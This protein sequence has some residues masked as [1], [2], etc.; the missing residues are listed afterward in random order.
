VTGSSVLDV[1]PLAALLLDLA[2]RK[3]SGRLAFGDRTLVLRSGDVADILPAPDDDSLE[4]FLVKSGRMSAATLAPYEQ[5][6]KGGA[7]ADVLVAQGAL[8]AGDLRQAR[9]ALLLDRLTRALRAAAERKGPLPSIAEMQVHAAAGA[10]VTLLPFLLDALA[11]Y[12]GSEDAA[13]VGAHLNHRIEWDDG[14]HAQTARAWADLGETPQRPAVSTVLAKRPA[15]APRIAALLRAGLIRLDAPGRA[16]QSS[17]P[18]AASLPPP[19]PRAVT[20]D[21]PAP[22]RDPLAAVKP[23]RLRLD[24][25]QVHVSAEPLASTVLPE[26]PPAGDTPSD[27]LVP[28]EQRIAEL[29]AQGAS[30]AERARAFCAIA[31]VWRDRF[32][33]LERACRAFREAATADPSLPGVLQ[34]AAIHCH[35]LG[36]HD[37]AL[38]YV[39]AAVSAAG[40]PVE[41]AGAQRLRARI[42][43]SAGDGDACI[44]ALC[45]AAAD[46]PTCPDSHEQVATLL[47]ERGQLEGANAHARLAATAIQEDAPDRALALLSFAWWLKPDDA[48]T[49]YEYASLLDAAGQR[50]VAVAVLAYTGNHVEQVDQGRKLRLAA[51]ERAEASGRADIAAELLVEAFDAE[52]HFDLLYGPLDED[53]AAIGLCEYRA[54]VLEDVATECPDE[55]RAYWLTRAAQVLL[56]AEGQH[57][58]AVWLLYEALLTEPRELDRLT[59]LRQHAASRR[60]LTLF[61]HGLRAAIAARLEHGRPAEDTA[62]AKRLL[63]E[64]AE[65]AQARLHNPHL[66]LA[67][68]QQRK[69]MGEQDQAAD[70]TIAS[71]GAAI[72]ARRVELDRAEQ[73][74]E[75]ASKAERA[76]ASLRVARL[77]PDI[78]EHWPRAIQLLTEGLSA[79]E[80]LEATR[81][82]LETLYGLSRDAIALATFLEEQAELCQDRVE[83]LRILGRLCAVHTVREDTFAVAAVCESLIGLDPSSRIAIARLERAARRLG[84]TRRLARALLLRGT[85][86][87][88]AR[89]RGRALVQLARTE[90]LA[91]LT[92]EAA[93]HAADALREDPNAA[94]AA[95]LLL[96]HIDRV[97]PE[98]AGFGLRVAAAV[99]GPSRALLSAQVHAA[100]ALADET[101]ERAALA[102][103]VALL[104]NDAAAHRACMRMRASARDA[105]GLLQAAEAA[106]YAI[107][108]AEMLEAAREAL[109]QLEQL[110]A[111][112]QAAELALR[113]AEEQGRPDPAL[114]ARALAAARAQPSH[115]LTAR[116]LEL[117][118]A[119]A[120]PGERA[121]WLFALADHH[122]DHGQ[123]AA[124]I[125]ALLRV[126]ELMPT[127]PAALQR[128]RELFVATGD[129]ARLLGVLHLSLDGERD[130]ARRRELRLQLCAIAA[131]PLQ[132]RE[133]AEFHVRALVAESF[134]QPDHVREALGV[135]VTLGGPSWAL[136]RCQVIAESCP[137]ELGSRIYQWCA[138]TA[139]Q[140]LHDPRL[141]FEVARRGALRWPAYAELLLMVERL[142]LSAD[143]THGAMEVYDAL[144]AAAIGP[145]GRRA[146]VYRAGRWLERAGLLE[147]ALARYVDAFGLAPSMGAAFKAV[148]RVARQTGQPERLVPCYEQLA[149]QSR[150]GRTRAAL[151]RTA[152]ELCVRELEDRPRGLSLLMQANAM[153][154]R[155][156][157]DDRLLEVARDLSLSDGSAGRVAMQQLAFE[158]RERVSQLWNAEDKL[159]CLLRLALVRSEGLGEHA[160]ALADLD[161]AQRVIEGEE[162]PPESPAAIEAARAVISARMTPSARPVPA[163]PA[164]GHPMRDSE[165]DRMSAVHVPAELLGNVLED[166]FPDEA[167]SAAASLPAPALPA[168]D[169]SSAKPAA[170]AETPGDARARLHR[171]LTAEPWRID[172]LRDLHALA[173][174]QDH[175]AERHVARQILSIFDRSV[176][177]ARDT[178]FHSGMWRGQAL[179]TSIGDDP[180]PELSGLLTMLWECARVIPRFRRPLASYG[181]NERDRI[182]RIT[183]GPVAEAYAQAARMLG[184]TDV[185]VYLLLSGRAPART[186]AT[187]PPAVLAS[188]G[189]AEEPAA[190]LYAM[191]HALWLAQPER[192]IGGVLP[193][194]EA[195]ELIDAARLA[196][197]PALARHANAGSKELAAALWQSVP[198]RDQRVMAD[199]LRRNDDALEYDALRA[200]ARSSAARAALLASGG[201]RFALTFLANTEPELEGVDLS[202]EPQ[203]ASACLGSPAL[204]ETIRCALSAPFMKALAQL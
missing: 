2:A 27:P 141:A 57:E 148:E 37:L 85:V 50:A 113:L 160:A 60:E 15:A 178:A 14:P 21:E 46:D 116:A 108:N 59:T 41:R 22:A 86:A 129:A 146:L 78:P 150:D 95:L 44:E 75:R 39:E 48:P 62:E 26:L 157:L 112:A 169:P 179:R 40:I 151:L 82:T 130:P 90:E 33:S 132:D 28:L 144:I 51:A 6:A 167:V 171:L 65:L 89:E 136:E 56:Q 133:R 92:T 99:C 191:A 76:R 204:A 163:E 94:D 88:S 162:L 147:P 63:H 166:V 188:R 122:R 34:Q 53:L 31:D 197:A 17:P 165:L 145:H 138:A 103:W 55:Q 115:R 153:S 164:A 83:R 156:E 16:V 155:Y 102:G 201:L 79:G 18:A 52:P 125:R 202:S 4:H 140:R 25:G 176:S 7:I 154:E 5:A 58:A 72:R 170:P 183:I 174:A 186:L 24:P 120:E 30:G 161:E 98:V 172:A 117:R 123:S 149:E 96:R 189:V 158:L 69:R 70:A 177:V 64:L 29:E 173:T 124:E 105:P 192:M 200:R 23:P 106:L 185:P 198:T 80:E 3:V 61:A 193:R 134:E 203:F 110:G 114:A 93:A 45:E 49:A 67:A 91:G 152:G 101:A 131:G 73:S 182:S 199:V 1:S 118:V 8:N 43:R 19:L 143:D 66:A 11:R 38:R 77:L 127:D 135:L 195:V 107:P 184:A 187:H 71:L 97:E 32:A 128:L 159:R 36:Q 81:E 196:F 87:Q 119:I 126:L 54:A 139:E 142:T 111:H 109:T 168:S 121:E 13:V 68:W 42:A 194:T 137:P 180:V 181:V 190:L 47:L 100:H 9:R 84:D 74:L 12:A 10:T 104:P 35:H 175:A 20:L